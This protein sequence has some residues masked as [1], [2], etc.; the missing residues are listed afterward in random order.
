MH[1]VN[2]ISDLDVPSSNRDMTIIPVTNA[3]AAN[4]AAKLNEILGAPATGQQ[5]GTNSET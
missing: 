1:V 2:I 4:I 5:G 3:E